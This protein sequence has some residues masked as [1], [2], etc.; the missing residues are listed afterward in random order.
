VKIP[1]KLVIAS[2]GAVLASAC[3]NSA[4]LNVPQTAG[5]ASSATQNAAAHPN[6]EAQQQSWRA[7]IARTPKPGNG[8]YTASYPQTAWI[9]V[10]CVEAPNRPYIPRSSAGGSQ[11]VGDGHDYAAMTATLTSNA[12]GS[13]PKVKHVTSETDG[14]RQ[15]VYSLQLNSNFISGDEACAGAYN[16][17]SC[18]GWLQYVY[19]SSSHAAFMQYWL[20]RYTGGSVHCPSGWNSF[21]PDCYKNS[22]AISVPQEPITDLK[23]ITLT[24]NAV[25]GG[26][27]R[28][29]HVPF[30][31][32]DRLRIQ[33][34]RRRWRI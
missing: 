12:V 22:S 33:R 11:T 5:G 2:L 20:I 31:R 14:G 32:L 6:V 8:C 18:L 26:L 19:S 23:A 3:S 21:S 25:S 27:D 28:H 24:G 29:G 30:G 1:H 7:A 34:H 15:N 17:S 13:F 4:A 10:Q 16:P 9:S